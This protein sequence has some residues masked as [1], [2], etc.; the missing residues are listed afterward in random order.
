MNAAFEYNDKG[1]ILYSLDCPGAFARGAG[2]EEA[3]AKLPADAPEFVVNMTRNSV[4]DT[5]FGK[6]EDSQT[7][8]SMLLWFD[9]ADDKA[10]IAERL[11]KQCAEADNHILCGIFGAKFLLDALTDNG[12]FDVAYEIATQKTY[13]GWFHMLSNGSDTLWESWEGGDSLNHHMFSPIDAWL[14][15]GI[16]GIRILEPGYKKVR[17]NPHVAKDMNY[18]KAWHN[19]P[20]GKLEVMYKDG[21]ITVTAPAAMEIEMDTDLENSIVRI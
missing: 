7:F 4:I 8:L 10:D 13:P 16:A 21:K 9:L 19:T 1:C 12:K 3:M 14:Y 17:I 5:Y 18:F 11:V 20:M 6:V 15:K 2:R